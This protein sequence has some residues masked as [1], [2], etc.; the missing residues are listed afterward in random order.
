MVR[1][2]VGTVKLFLDTSVLVFAVG[3]EH[4]QRSHCAA[5]IEAAAR[6]DVEVHMSAEAIQEFIHHR[7]RRSSRSL[8][9]AQARAARDLALIH[10]FDGDVLDTAMQL[11]E[12]TTL[13]GRDAV[14][15][16]TALLGGFDRIV[17]T[18]RDFAAVPGLGPVSPQRALGNT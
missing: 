18:D 14:H 5:L 11:I 15:A 4:K 8:A 2:T 10:P 17:T 13:R 1:A 12:S 16:A 7:M 9:L 3:T 6:G